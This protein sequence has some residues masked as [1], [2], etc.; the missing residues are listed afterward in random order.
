MSAK[1]NI[2]PSKKAQ[3]NNDLEELNK[4]STG[5]SKVSFHNTSDETGDIFV[6]LNG[7]A[8]QIKRE[9]EV[10]LP[11]EVLGVIDD[12]VITRFERDEKGGELT[13]DIKRFPY[14]KV[15]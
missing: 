10:S 1:K 3:A 7:V 12:A 2:A 9:E 13:R 11:N 8:Y 6:Q 14:T 5:R 15:A 4:I